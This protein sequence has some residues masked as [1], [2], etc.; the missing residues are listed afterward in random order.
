MCV[1]VLC[2][3]IYIVLLYT[4]CSLVY[5]EEKFRNG[6]ERKI[7]Q[8]PHKIPPHPPAHINAA[9]TVQRK[10]LRR[11]LRVQTRGFTAGYRQVLAEEQ[12]VERDG[13]A[14]IRR[15]TISRMGALRDSSTGTAHYALPKTAEL[16]TSAVGRREQVKKTKI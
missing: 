2:A 16:R 9:N 15:A 3:R 14:R 13:M 10:I 1:C 8:T 11:C 5:F 4:F 6:N 7:D 12:I